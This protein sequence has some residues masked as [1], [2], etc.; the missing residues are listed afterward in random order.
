MSLIDTASFY[1]PDFL[2]G[3][4]GAVFV[5]LILG[6]FLPYFAKSKSN[7]P[8]KPLGFGAVV[9]GALSAAGVFAALYFINNS[10]ALMVFVWSII[11]GIGGVLSMTDFAFHRAPNIYNLN[12]FVLVAGAL[13]INTVIEQNWMDLV[14]ALVALVG[15]AVI[16]FPLLYVVKLGAGDIKYI[17][18]VAMALGYLNIYLAVGYLIVA[19]LLNFVF[20]IGVLIVEKSRGVP[21]KDIKGPMIPPYYYG[22]AVLPLFVSSGMIGVLG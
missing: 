14:W 2:I 17:P 10:T 6:F 5:A 3:V 21:A 8:F 11:A 4:F 22:L 15:S 19:Y 13:V 16:L 18:T 20:S 12:Q 9:I 7:P 1:L